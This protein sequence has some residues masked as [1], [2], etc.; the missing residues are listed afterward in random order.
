MI[1]TL[2]PQPEPGSVGPD[3]GAALPLVNPMTVSMAVAL[4]FLVA[5]LAVVAARPTDAYEVQG[6]DDRPPAAESP[7][8]MAGTAGFD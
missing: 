5:V 7:A 8:R 1:D 3:E 2:A 6:A 4:T